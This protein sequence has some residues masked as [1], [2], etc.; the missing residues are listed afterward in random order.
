MDY[1]TALLGSVAGGVSDISMISME[2]DASTPL[3]ALM[4]TVRLAGVLLIF[5]YW[6]KFFTRNEAAGDEDGRLIT[7]STDRSDTP[8]DRLARTPGQK[9]AFTLA[10]SILTGILGNAS[11]MPAGAMVFPMFAVAALNITTSVCRVPVQVKNVAQLLA[12]ALVGCSMKRSTFADMDKVLLPLLL[13]LV[14]YWG[15]NLIYSLYCKRRRLLDLKSAMFASAPGGATDMSL[16]AADLNA[17]LTKIALIQVL[18]AVYAVTVMPAAIT[19][20]VYF[21]Q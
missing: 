19:L 2:M 1:T 16:I 7:G 8:L 5:P 20:F 15:V 3:V 13:L 17:D 12:G 21:V 10:V 11:G 9:I 18:R 14:N 6:I 4:Q